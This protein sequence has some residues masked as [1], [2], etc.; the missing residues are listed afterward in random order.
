MASTT[1]NYGFPYPEDTDVV[2]VAGDIQALAEDIDSKLSETIADTVGAM[3]T[4]NTENGISVTYDDSDNTLDFD[5]ADF[6]ITFN[7]DVSGSTTINNLA[8]ASATITVIDDSHNHSSSTISDFAEAVADTVGAMV[9]SNTENGITVTYDDAD[10]TLDFDV[11]DFDITLSGDLVG[12]ATVTNLGN[13]TISASV[14][15]SSHN[16]IAADVTDFNSTVEGIIDAFNTIDL[17]NGTDP[18]ATLYNDTLSITESNGIIVTGTGSNTIDI[19]TNA[20]SADTS[21]TIVERDASGKFAISGI[22]LNTS[23]S[24]SASAGLITW[25]QIDGTANLGLEDDVNLQIGQES[26]VRVKNET[27]SEIVDGRI[28]C[29][30]GSGESTPG[31]PAHPLI[32]EFIADGSINAANVIGLTTHHIQDDAHGYVTAFGMVRD[33]DTSA[34]APGTVLYASSSSAGYLTDLQP[35]SPDLTVV[36]GVVVESDAIIGSIFVNPRVY[37]TADLVTYD[38]TDAFLSATNVK[39]ALDELSLGKADISALASNIN[40][41]PTTASAASPSGYY[42]M[43]SDI[44]D[45]N[46]NDTAVDIPTGAIS[47]SAQL[48]ASLVSASGLITGNPGVINVT[49]I[50]NIAKTAGNKNNYAEFFFRIYHRDSS[51]TETLLGTS[52]T[53]GAVNPGDLDTYEQFSAAA[54]VNFITF[55]EEDRIVIKYYANVLGGTASEYNFQFGGDSP[56]R[57]LLPVPVS[58]IPVADASGIIVDTSA[59]NGVLSG[60]D[61]T[62]QAALNTLDDLDV[63]PSQTGN[64]GKFLGTDG[65]NATWETVDALPSQTGNDGKYLTTDGTTASWTTVETGGGS[66]VATNVAL[67]QSWWLGV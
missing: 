4:S 37:A 51:G 10:N 41:Y 62:V 14:L 56:V 44:E 31:H 8:S 6:D 5:V 29:V 21:S 30:I 49:T 48:L 25:N 32:A 65:T 42:L 3:V 47:A 24:I 27:G 7:G 13:V 52:N 67:S 58:V 22:E 17:P 16:H 55:A 59:F 46:Y 33:I 23:A 38:N 60:S 53:T 18:V 36:V 35:T 57:T 34:Y 2:D 61:T 9:T 50:G 15:D 40:L 26:H 39:G 12:S 43:V 11:A 64:A 19:S 20:T 63:L 45:A 66:G 54:V 1:T 28:V